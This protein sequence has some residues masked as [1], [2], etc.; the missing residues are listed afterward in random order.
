MGAVKAAIADGLMTF[1]WVICAS[2]LRVLTSLISGYIGVSETQTWAS[3]LI[4]AAI[5]FTFLFTFGI[6]GNLLGGATFNPT[7]TAAFYAAGLDSSLS[8]F[9]AALRFPAQVFSLFL[10]YGFISLSILHPNLFMHLF[11]SV[12]CSISLL[13][14]IVKWGNLGHI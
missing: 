11:F 12:I 8:L 13:G 5:L 9:S 14:Q 2:S 4:T 3:L 6:I 1:M 7:A 10:Y